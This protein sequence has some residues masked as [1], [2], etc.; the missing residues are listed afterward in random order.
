MISAKHTAKRGYL[1]HMFMMFTAISVFVLLLAAGSTTFLFNSL[2]TRT[3]KQDNEKLLELSQKIEDG[4]FSEVY[5]NVTQL[6]TSNAVRRLL[7]AEDA[8]N[9]TALNNVKDLLVQMSNAC[10]FIDSIYVVLPRLDKI[11][12]DYG[13]FFNYEN[14]PDKSWLKVADASQSY[15]VWI[16]EHEIQKVRYSETDRVLTIV[17]RLP[18]EISSSNTLGY[19]VI[20]ID[21]DYLKKYTDQNIDSYSKFIIW[22]ENQNIACAAF[23]SDMDAK[24]L[25]KNYGNIDFSLHSQEIEMDGR[26]LIVTLNHSTVVP[27]WSYASYSDALYLWEKV[28]STYIGIFAAGLIL[29][30]LTLAIVY[31]GSTVIYR[32]IEDLSRTTQSVPECAKGSLEKYEELNGI[33]HR[34]QDVINENVSI[35]ET[36]RENHDT[37]VERFYIS[38]LLGYVSATPETFAYVQFLHLHLSREYHYAVGLIQVFS[39]QKQ[40]LDCELDAYR[41]IAIP[42]EARRIAQKKGYDCKV[43]ELAS[44]LLAVVLGVSV[45]ELTTRTLFAYFDALF[46]FIHEK[47]LTEATVCISDPVHDLFQVS[48]AFRQANGLLKYASDYN[49]QELL[50]YEHFRDRTTQTIDF[51]SCEKRLMQAIHAGSDEAV[52]QTMQTLHQDVEKRMLLPEQ[53]RATLSGIFSIVS[54]STQD[55]KSDNSHP[56]NELILSDSG[57]IDELFNAVT[58]RLASLARQQAQLV[59]DQMQQTATHMVDY[60]KENYQQDIGLTA[61][62]E[63]FLYTPSYI[64]RI[65]RL[66]TRKTFYELLT[67]IRIEKAKEY[68]TTTSYSILRISELVGYINVQ[69]FI[70]MFKK[71]TG[72]TPG[73]YRGEAAKQ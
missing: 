47:L 56:K 65:L 41:R 40:P 37:L 31:K 53:V 15:M 1:K 48:D 64:N 45:E 59:Q 10:S 23:D 5:N 26:R 25:K 57:T 43:V 62:S 11:I 35:K 50:M 36:I 71:N 2:I 4:I 58:E 8:T 51:V 68:L 14:F 66:A 12:T 22:D 60:L 49:R 30:A 42:N 17:S 52:R 28:R 63:A 32:P 61:M 19:G 9:Y 54:F 73:V 69:S 6:S 67:D 13:F 21:A 44:G 72:C 3:V 55:N 27:G 39:P 20:N 16:G 29:L 46:T 18:Y 33:Y 34:Y 70:R 24:K 7:Y 38:L